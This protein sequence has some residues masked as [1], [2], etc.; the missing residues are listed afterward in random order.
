MSSVADDDPS[1]VRLWEDALADEV[2]AGRAER[3][4]GGPIVCASGISPSGP[5]HLGNL[6]ILARVGSVIGRSGVG[7]AGKSWSS[8]AEVP[9]K[10]K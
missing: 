2:I 4:A 7:W 1:T 6:P 10:E 3:N 9:K 8:K 5:I